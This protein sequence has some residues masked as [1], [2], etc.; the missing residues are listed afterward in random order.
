MRS[1]VW[2]VDPAARADR[3]EAI[4]GELTA[5][6]LTASAREIRGG[7]AIVVDDPPADLARPAEVIRA[8]GIELPGDGALT[9]RAFLDAFAASLAIGAVAASAG[10]VARF[11]TPPAVRPEDVGEV[12]VASLADLKAKGAIRFRFGRE[13]CIL[14]HSGTAVFALS[15]VCTHLGCLVDWSPAR[16][17]LVCPCHG[18]AF[19]LEGN[20][21]EGPPPRPLAT[22]T[23]SVEGDRVLVRKRNGA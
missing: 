13:P 23:V 17:Q 8:A 11:A 9:R 20:V 19:D 22:M 2:V 12:E 1:V 7:I 16:R 6:G 4:V 21:L 3:V 18:A 10:V 5:Q 14:V 15:L